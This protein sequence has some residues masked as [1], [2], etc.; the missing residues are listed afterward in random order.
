MELKTL[1][2]LKLN[3]YE[4]HIQSGG[5]SGPMKPGNRLILVTVLIPTVRILGDVRGFYEYSPLS[6]RRR[7]FYFRILL[8]HQIILKIKER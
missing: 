1:L 2:D 7:I 5:G 3:N 4:T 6:C 8:K